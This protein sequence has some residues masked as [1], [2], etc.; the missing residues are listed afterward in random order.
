MLNIQIIKQGKLLTWL[1]DIN[2]SSLDDMGY[3]HIT[4]RS[5]RRL[6]LRRS[7]RGPE[8]ALVSLSLAGRSQWHLRRRMKTYGA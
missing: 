2:I 8:E 6:L 7:R 5:T 4:Q 1:G 3:E